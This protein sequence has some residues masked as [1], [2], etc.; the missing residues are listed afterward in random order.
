MVDRKPEVPLFL[1]RAGTDEF[2]PPP[3]DEGQRRAARSVGER[4]PLDAARVG[5]SLGDYWSSRLG[6]AAGLLAINAEAGCDYY[7]VP[8]LAATDQAAADAA[9][10]GGEIVVDVHTH[11]MADREW[12][13]TVADWQKEMYK[14]IGPEWWDGF[15]GM[16]FYSLEDYLRCVFLESETAVAVLTS[17][18]ADETGVPFLTGE[19]LFGTRR[20]IDRFA[21]TGRVLNQISVQPTEPGVF[22]MLERWRDD[23]DPVAWK[24]YTM[25]R[26]AK[27]GG[28]GYWEPGTQWMLD[29]EATGLPF[30]EQSQALGVRRVCAHKGMSGLVDSGSPRDIGA[31]ARMF[32][33]M[34]FA[35]YHSAIEVELVEGP[36]TEATAAEGSNRLVTAMLENGLPPGSNVF[37]DLG[38]TWFALIKRPQEAAHLLGKLLLHVGED[39]IMW[40]T[41]GTWYGP[42]QPAIDAFRSFQIPDDLCARYGYPKLT[43]E[44]RSKILGRNAGRFYELDLD[45]TWRAAQSD[46]LAWTRAALLASGAIP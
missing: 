37:A 4:G 14:V 23:Y 34:A 39:N 3:L 22:D 35:A 29:D 45:A 9:F 20:L 43:P 1:R 6:T 33:D 31:V 12:L 15:E 21:G 44:I 18:P 8:S 41:D 30:L 36:Y 11:Y 38:T 25:G 19:E 2:I 27:V 10:G 16:G 42:T 46:D 26:M 7:E 13:H 5:R 17:P 24:V 28:D 32:P 40:G